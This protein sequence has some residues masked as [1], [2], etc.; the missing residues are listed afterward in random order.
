MKKALLF[1]AVGKIDTDILESYALMD[2]R[3]RSRRRPGKTKRYLV[4]LLA[5]VL[6]VIL[7]FALLVTTLPLIYITNAEKINTAISDVVDGVMFPMDQVPEGEEIKH[8]DLLLN[9]VEWDFTKDFFSA[10]GAG[11]EDSVIDKLQGMQS[12]GLAGESMQSLGD[13]LARL[14]EYY[15]KY[16][17]LLF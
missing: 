10:L 6:A 14:Y 5:A 12:D 7:S 2:Q 3:L 9:W 13:L 15:L 17:T 11:T 4:A 1:D 8:E 16:K